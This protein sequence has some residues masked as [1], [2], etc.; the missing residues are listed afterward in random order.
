M[1]ANAARMDG[2]GPPTFGSPMS[3]RTHS[4]HV[5]ELPESPD[6]SHLPSGR[7]YDDIDENIDSLFAVPVQYPSNPSSPGTTPPTF[8]EQQ[9]HLGEAAN[10]LVGDTMSTTVD[11]VPR[12]AIGMATSTYQEPA[13]GRL[14]SA[15]EEPQRR[16]RLTSEDKMRTLIAASKAIEAADVAAGLLPASTPATRKAVKRAAELAREDI[17]RAIEHK[18]PIQ[19]PIPAATLKKI[20]QGWTA[21]KKK[22]R[23]KKP[24]KTK[25]E[26]KKQLAKEVAAVVEVLAELGQPAPTAKKP[27]PK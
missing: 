19:S 17:K 16:S 14:R 15:S 26:A 10:E 11:Y 27:P 23:A 22:P 20:E 12:H 2:R 1:D 7:E 24:A 13:R 6:L 21:K 8:E 4:E 18:D 9:R 3:L 25:K 5:I